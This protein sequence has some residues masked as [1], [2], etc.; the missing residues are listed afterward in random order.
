MDS[1]IHRVQEVT[2]TSRDLGDD[3]GMSTRIVVSSCHQGKVIED[4][5]TL[6]SNDKVIKNFNDNVVEHEEG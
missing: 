2:I 1:S 3:L 5:I 6:F 4:Q